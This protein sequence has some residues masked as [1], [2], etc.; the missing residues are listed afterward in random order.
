MRILIFTAAQNAHIICAAMKITTRYSAEQLTEIGRAM[1]RVGIED[2]GEFII[3]ATSK[4]AAET[5]KKEEKP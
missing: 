2:V 1:E 4:Q 5:L 3:W